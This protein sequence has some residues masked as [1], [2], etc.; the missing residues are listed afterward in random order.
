MDTKQEIRADLHSHTTASDGVLSPSQLVVEAAKRAITHL[1]ITD[2]DTVAGVPEGQAAAKK[3]GIEVVPGIEITASVGKQVVHILGLG[4]DHESAALH[5][6][7]DEIVALRRGRYEEMLNRLRK[8]CG[9]ELPPNEEFLPEVSESLTRPRLARELLAL[10]LVKDVDDAFKRFLGSSGPAFVPHKVPDVALAMKAIDA[11]GGVASLAHCGLY[12][13][14]EEIAEKLLD[15]G[16]MAIEVHH[17]DHDFMRR[18]RLL[19]LAHGRC[20]LVTGG[21]DFHDFDSPK[22]KYFGNCYTNDND[23]RRLRATWEG[24]QARA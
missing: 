11:A 9:L 10:G 1:A 3:A 12:A 7:T 14:G 18:N 23:F 21:G 13:A 19:K 17:P 6:L 16:L 15:R 4:I 22:S 8:K 20:A 24:I 5:K 2:H